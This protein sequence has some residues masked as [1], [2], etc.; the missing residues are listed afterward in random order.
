MAGNRATGERGFDFLLELRDEIVRLDV[1]VPDPGSAR[2][3]AVVRALG[4]SI[5]P[6]TERI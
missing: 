3:R 6:G 2:G 5:I 4:A 1:A